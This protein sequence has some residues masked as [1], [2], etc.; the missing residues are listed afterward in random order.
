MAIYTGYFV[1]KGFL[2]FLITSPNTKTKIDA[3]TPLWV[4]H[5]P[6]LISNELTLILGFAFGIIFSIKRNQKVEKVTQKIS[7]LSTQF[8]NKFFIPVLPLFV[9]GFI[10]KLQHEDVL[11]YV[12]KVYGKVLLVIVSTQISYLCVAYLIASNFSIKRLAQY[13][14]AVLP[15][16]LTGFSTLSS[17]ASMGVLITSMER[18]FKNKHTPNLYKA[19]IPSVI[20]IHIVG[21]AIGMT[22]LALATIKSCGMQ[23]PTLHVFAIF[24]LFYGIS[25]FAVV[26]V[27]GGVLLIVIPLLEK[28]LA[29]SPEMIGVVTVV[30]LLFDP[31]GTA[32]NIT[33]NGGFTIIF[34]KIF[35]FLTKRKIS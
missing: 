22:I 26:A 21:S 35:N 9:F 18:I 24:A 2:D 16:T 28:Y 6:T 14:S 17:A 8:L 7:K 27:P 34:S 5:I 11:E 30:Y 23:T 25:T 4:P 19:I 1:G 31:F 3:L 10:L 33:M 15:A 20:N 13:I 12:M 32:T 29:F